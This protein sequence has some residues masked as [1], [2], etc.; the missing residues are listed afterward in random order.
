[1]NQDTQNTETTVNDNAPQSLGIRFL[2][3]HG[4]ANLKT[5]KKRQLKRIEW[6][7][8]EQNFTNY[9]TKSF[10]CLVALC[11]DPKLVLTP[12]EKGEITRS[13]KVMAYRDYD[14]QLKTLAQSVQLRGVSQFNAASN[15]MSENSLVMAPSRFRQEF[16]LCYA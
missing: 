10:R 7:L 16:L 11:Q 3:C 5:F 14:K 6:F 2:E 9:T 1:M 13:M 4:V 8:T 12:N 15:E